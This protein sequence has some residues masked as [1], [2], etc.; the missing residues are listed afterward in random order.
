MQVQLMPMLCKQVRKRSSIRSARL[1]IQARR[2]I[3]SVPQDPVV[4]RLAA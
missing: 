3:S 1:K 4:P 2:N